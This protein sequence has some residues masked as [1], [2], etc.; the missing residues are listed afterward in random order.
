MTYRILMDGR[1]IDRCTWPGLLCLQAVQ[2]EEYCEDNGYEL[3]DTRPNE[4]FTE[5][6]VTVKTA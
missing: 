6:S 4:S 3:V 1:E 2:L 5:I